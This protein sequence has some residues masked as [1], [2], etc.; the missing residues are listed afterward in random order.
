MKQKIHLRKFKESDLYSYKK[1]FSNV[2]S[3]PVDDN[4]F[5][6]KHFKNP[7]N[8]N[9]EALIYLAM[10]EKDEIVGSNAF[11][12]AKF[13]FQEKQHIVVQSG[14]TLVLKEYRNQGIFKEIMRFAIKDLKEKGYEAIYGF[15]NNNSLPGFLGLGFRNMCRIYIFFQILCYINVFQNKIKK[16]PGTK[17]VGKSIDSLTKLKTFK[18]YNLYNIEE[19]NLDD[20][21]FSRVEK[22]I[23]NSYTNKIYQNKS[24]SYLNWKFNDRPYKKYRI[25]IVHKEQ[26]IIGLFV[27]NIEERDYLKACS[28]I[29]YFIDKNENIDIAVKCLITYYKQKRLDY[30]TIW[31]IGDEDMKR[32]LNRNLF[33][34]TRSSS[35]FILKLLNDNL[36]FMYNLKLWHITY[37]DTDNA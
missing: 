29:E 24:K 16:F 31:N 26:S 20:I 17:L 13:V 23:L 33:I 3:K 28:I 2:F 37:G 27:V 19:S 11:F 8:V 14:D 25:I 9:G 7:N 1:V 36:Q 35:Y 12:P 32:S 10:N 4:Y 34:P 5:N 18:E 22:Y 6:W 15:A 21:D 30:L